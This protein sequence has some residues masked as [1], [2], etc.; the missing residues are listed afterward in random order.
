MMYPGP[1]VYLNPVFYKYL[2]DLG[3]DM[4]FYRKIEMIPIGKFVKD[5][6]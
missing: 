3:E 2:E 6:V 4:Q 1:Y 5:F